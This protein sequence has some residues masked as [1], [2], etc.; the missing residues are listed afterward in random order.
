[1]WICKQRDLLLHLSNAQQVVQQ[2][3]NLLSLLLLMMEK[4][5]QMTGCPPFHMLF[6]VTAFVSP[7]ISKPDALSVKGRHRIKTHLQ[8][9]VLME[10]QVPAESN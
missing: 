4:H 7:Y 3:N 1:M 6:Y 8:T 2:V 5:S 10:L 9:G